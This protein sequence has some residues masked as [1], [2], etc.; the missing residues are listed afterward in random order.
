[1]KNAIYEKPKCGYIPVVNK[2]IE[3]IMRIRRL[4]K[5]SNSN[6]SFILPK[7]EINDIIP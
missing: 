2:I 5:N 4:S 1:M 3:K 6:S 7:P